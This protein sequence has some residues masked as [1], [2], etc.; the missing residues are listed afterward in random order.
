MILHQ[1]KMNKVFKSDLHNCSICFIKLFITARISLPRSRV[2]SRRIYKKLCQFARSLQE[3]TTVEKV[4]YVFN[5]LI[6]SYIL[7]MLIRAVM[8]SC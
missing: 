7:N 5:S 8:I 4:T 2:E 6:M 1:E 3:P